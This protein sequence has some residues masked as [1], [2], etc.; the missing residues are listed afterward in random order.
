ME[1]N[2][3]DE[4]KILIPVAHE[5]LSVVIKAAEGKRANQKELEIATMILKGLISFA[6]SAQ[7]L[8]Q[9]A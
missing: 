6:E 9:V 4:L 8:K 3:K 7:N 1:H 2:Q 5:A